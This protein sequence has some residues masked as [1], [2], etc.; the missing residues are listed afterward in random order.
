MNL[1]NLEEKE[2]RAT[3]IPCILVGTIVSFIFYFKEKLYDVKL[4]V[5]CAIG[6]TIGAIIG[7]RIL[8]KIDNKILKIIFIIFLGYTS[9]RYITF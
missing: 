4:G 7:S 8:K 3:A 1:L 9:F 6:G 5:L 2:A